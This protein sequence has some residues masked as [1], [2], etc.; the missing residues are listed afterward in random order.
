MRPCPASGWMT[1]AASPASATRSPI[2]A[3]RDVEADREA[4]AR[5]GQLR[6]RQE[7]AGLLG[8]LQLEI[9]VARVRQAPAATAAFSV[10]IRLA[11]SSG[12]RQHGHRPVGQEDLPRRA[13]VRLCP[14]S[15]SS[16]SR[17]RHSRGL[18][19]GCPPPRRTSELRPSQPTTSGA[20]IPS[21]PSF[22]T[23]H[24]ARQSVPRRSAT[25]DSS[26]TFGFGR[27]AAC[28]T[29]S[30]AARIDHV[31]K[32]R[33]AAVFGD[34][35]NAADAA[36][37]L[38]LRHRL[39]VR[40]QLVLDPQ[41]AENPPAAMGDEIGPA[42]R[43]RALS[44]WRGARRPRPPRTRAGRAPAPASGPRVRPRQWRR[45]SGRCSGAGR[46]APDIVHPARKEKGARPNDRAPFFCPLPG[47]APAAPACRG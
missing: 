13:I 44:G 35:R 38:D 4:D 5:A 15:P 34:E 11:R 29:A 19:S 9:C 23:A 17:R 33:L 3:F 47:A 42:C 24:R 36:L 46:H 1:C 8:Q 39:G 30:S 45:R 26:F 18:R 10:Q 43:G 2:E 41:R 20:A 21:S 22:R 14:A 37:G 31:A 32:R 25:P 12:Q 28:S 27:T 16:R 6:I 7:S 40:Q